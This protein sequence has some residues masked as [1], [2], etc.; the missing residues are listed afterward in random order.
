MSRTVTLEAKPKRTLIFERSDGRSLT[1]EKHTRNIL[2]ENKALRGEKGAD[3]TG[4]APTQEELSI[5][6]H[7]ALKG[8]YVVTTRHPSGQRNLCTYE[9]HDGY[10]AHTLTWGVNGS[11]QFTTSRRQFTYGGE[12]WIYEIEHLWTVDGHNGTQINTFT[13]T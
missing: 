1:L 12:V 9:D 10:T 5:L 2:L 13:R 3:G 4:S 7:A 11:G 6:D 8:G